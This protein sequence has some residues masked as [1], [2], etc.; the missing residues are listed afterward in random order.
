MRLALG[1]TRP[2]VL[3]LVITRGMRLTLVGLAVGLVGSLVLARW[4][5]TLL[6]AVSPADPLVLAGGV[7]VLA[8]VALL[9]CHVPARRATRVDPVV[10]LLY[11]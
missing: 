9:A 7:L 8:A 1:A 4:I 3:R 5:R 10:A 6:F 2:E 11:E